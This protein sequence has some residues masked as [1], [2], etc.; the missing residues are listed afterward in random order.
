MRLIAGLL[1]MRVDRCCGLHARRRAVFISGAVSFRARAASAGRGPRAAAAKFSSPMDSSAEGAGGHTTASAASDS[2]WF[3]TLARPA[4]TMMS[5]T[6][7][8]NSSRSGW[9][10]T[11]WRM[12]AIQLG[13]P[14][15]ALRSR[16]P[17][18]AFQRRR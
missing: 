2:G 6:S 17:L 14:A 18:L 4:S 8:G 12:A 5:A 9:F 15:H 11:A 10:S 13:P 3:T 1:A 16:R 7:G